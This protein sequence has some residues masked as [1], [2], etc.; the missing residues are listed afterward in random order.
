M[1]LFVVDVVADIQNIPNPKHG[2]QLQSLNHAARFH[3][4]VGILRRRSS[5]ELEFVVSLARNREGSKY[6][7]VKP[8]R[9]KCIKKTFWW[10]SMNE[11]EAEWCR[12]R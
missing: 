11:S 12:R 2:A 8:W 10:E 1:N 5:P 7:R 9:R 6:W 3:G 4:I